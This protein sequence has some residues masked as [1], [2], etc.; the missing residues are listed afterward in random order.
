MDYTGCGNS[1]NVRH[2]RVL[3]LI[4]DSL[5][6]WVVDM[7]VWTAFVS[8]WRAPWRAYSS[9]WTVSGHFSISST[10]TRSCPR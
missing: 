2:P 7:H 6:Y 1:L 9:T 10:R 5:R 3:Q 8:I 4:M